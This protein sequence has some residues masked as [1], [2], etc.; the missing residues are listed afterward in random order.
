MKLSLRLLIVLLIALLPQEG[1]AQC[2]QSTPFSENFDGSSWVSPTG[3]NNN[4]SVPSCWT[5]NLTT[6]NYL[7]MASDPAFVSTNSGPAGDHTTGTGGYAF[8]EGWFTG[9]TSANQNV[10]NLITPPIDL[11]SD[12]LPRLV[13]YYHMFGSDITWLNIKVRKVGTTSWVNV[14]TFN[15]S[16][17]S[18]Q[19]TSNSSSWRKHV[20]SLSQFAGDTVQIRFNAKRNSSFSWFTNS[21]IAIDDILIEET[22]SCDQPFNTIVT[23]TTPSGATLNWSSL[24]SSPLSFQ[25]QYIVSTGSVINGSIA[26]YT[27]KPST[28][29]G[30]LS[31]TNYKVRVRE[32][33]AAGDT[34][35]WSTTTTF[36][37]QCA[38]YIAPY[39]EDFEG[40]GWA[41][42]TTWNVQGDIDPCWNVQGSA[43][44]FWNVGEPAFNWTQTGPSGDHTSGSGQYVYHQ[45][46]TTLSSGL[47]P[48]LISPWIDL[49]T[50]SDPELSFWYHGY[51]Q[52][53]G[54]L[55]VR[56]QTIGGTWSSV[57]DTSGITHNSA[58]AP[59]L[60]QII[61]LTSYAGDT[62]RVRFDYSG[63]SGSFYTQFALDDLSLSK[64]PECPKPKLTDVT[65]VG[66]QVAQLDWT[67]GGA[68]DFQI[69]Y[70]SVG[71]T[72]WTWTTAATSAKGI[73]GLSP[74]TTYEWQVR[75]SCGLASVSDWV[76]GPSFTTNCTVFTAPFLE[77]F[78]SNTNWVGP[79]FPDQ[80]GAI[81]DCW[82]RSDSTDYFWTGKGV[83]YAGTGPSADH[84]TG[85]GG[86]T[87]ARSAT[88]F[89]A[90]ADTELRTPW[91]DLD[92][93]HSPELIFWYHMYGSDIDELKVFIKPLGQQ[94][95]L[96]KSITGQ[97]QA[98]STSSWLK[99]T[100]S[101][102]AYENDTIQIIFKAYRGN[103]SPFTPF[104]ADIALDDIEIDETT[105]CPTPL[106]T[107]SNITYNSAQLDWNGNSFTSAIEYDLA[108]F[109]LGSGTSMAASGQT[110]MVNGLQP[111]TTYDAWVQDSCTLTLNSLWSMVQFTTLPCPA[112][113]A[114]GSF[115][116]TGSSASGFSTTLN[117]DSTVWFWGDGTFSNADTATHTYTTFGSF[118]I[119]QVVY[120]S[121]G[122]T[123][124]MGFT[125]SLCD[126]T[127]LNPT[128]VVNGLQVEF[129]AVSSSSGTGL[130]YYWNFGNGT[131]GQGDTITANYTS[132][133]IYTVSL[134]A[135][136][137]C[138]DSITSSFVITL[139]PIVNLTFTSTVLG[140][141]FTFT[142]QPSN[143]LN[144]QWDFGDGNIASGAVV[145]NSYVTNGT[146]TVT[147]SGQDSCG[148]TF[149]YSDIV[150]T[151]DPPSGDFTFTLVGTGSN[152]LIVD[153]QAIA[154]GANQYHWFWGDG[155]FDK[156]TTPNAQHTYGVITLNYAVTL[157]L[158]NDCGDTTTVTR[159]L[160]E[161]GI[162]EKGTEC[163]LYPNPTSISLRVEF[164]QTMKTRIQLFAPIGS[165]VLDI[166]SE[167]RSWIDID[168]SDFPSATYTLRVL[169]NDQ[170]HYY[171]VV[172]I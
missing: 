46:T 170:W 158:I 134:L 96:L 37:T 33:C 101:L 143:L 130:V 129:D 16:T 97:K 64:A 79:G 103:G 105:S 31:N 82:L 160:N 98:L 56:I 42:S 3:W 50:I 59:W 73:P 116:N 172:K 151:C 53:M 99:Q 17:T 153:F 47:D 67:S 154:T 86:Y 171:P 138:G 66:V 80:N 90:G 34:S 81:D 123:D 20:E 68:S 131:L 147:V 1:E 117:A 4:G 13:F 109:N 92:T 27:S 155:T 127:I 19:F 136:N 48:R 126:T 14:H 87:F 119:Y 115:V 9:F 165:V 72:I 61:D 142:A 149:T 121:C 157:L 135:V 45:I 132:A 141:S 168:M 88:P 104:K 15:S 63:A 102:L 5:R 7:W 74:K 28:L 110:A 150:A 29:S 30:L 10:T 164:P 113:V 55:N 62:V 148:N 120:N 137:S 41:P 83:H 152:G 125:L 60:E 35:L 70:R 49:D 114:A 162:T 111:N 140:N 75:D 36:R 89:S 8:S 133:G 77:E 11:S 107:A 25:V 169:I 24:N 124:S 78:S 106:V 58:N 128:Y 156:G 91:I 69:R 43:T 122:S 51:G 146:F 76:S 23:Q 71:S 84:T 94:A 85:S 118:A 44:K 57:W 144:Y 22:P 2:I 161:V 54:A 108:N 167:N 12:T 32:I 38:Q 65:G 95:L 145:S 26:N 21:R 40:T 52:S 159:S 100:L 93:L 163:R 139:C 6:R 39:F 166:T 18:S 112:L